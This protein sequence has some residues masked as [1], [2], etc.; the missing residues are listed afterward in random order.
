MKDSRRDTLPKPTRLGRLIGTMS[1]IRPWG[2]AVISVRI[3]R[4]RARSEEFRKGLRRDA[5][6]L[7]TVIRMDTDSRGLAEGL[8]PP[9]NLS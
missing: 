2:P 5:T 7:G 4:R 1:G 6:P 8:H 9:E 3:D